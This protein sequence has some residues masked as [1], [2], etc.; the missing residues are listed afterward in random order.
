MSDPQ[1]DRGA[2]FNR[3]VQHA[4]R[5]FEALDALAAAGGIKA[6]TR[7]MKPASAVRL[8]DLLRSVKASIDEALAT[9]PK[10]AK[11]KRKTAAAKTPGPT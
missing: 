9:A 6:V 7:G 3:C 5:L 2:V 8:A 1:P 4:D 10:A 11:A